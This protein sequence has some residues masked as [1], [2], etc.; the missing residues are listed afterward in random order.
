VNPKLSGTKHNVFGIQTGVAISF[1]V[2]R[3]TRQGYRIFYARRPEFETADEKLEF[4]GSA[5]MERIKFDEI[6]PD[7]KGNWINLADTDFDSLLPILDPETKVASKSSREKAIF[8]LFGNGVNTARDEWVTDF[9]GS[10]LESKVRLFLS[11]YARHTTK[12][13]HHD[14]VIKWSRNLKSKLD[15]GQREL[16]DRAYVRTYAYRPYVAVYAYL[17]RLMIDELGQLEAF[18]AS[19]NVTIN[20]PAGKDFRC[21]ATTLPSD[22]HYI[23]DTKVLGMYRYDDT[24]RRVDN[25]TDWALHQ[26]DKQYQ[27][28][29]AKPKRPID[30][31]AIFHYVYGVLHDPVYREKYTLNLKREF[32]RIPLYANFWR[33]SDWGKELMELHISYESVAPAKMKRTDV[34]DE[35][36]KKAGL[37]PKAMLKAD[38]EAGRI[39]LDSETTLADIPPEA[40]EYRLGNRSA[41]EWILDQYR[42]SK[43][44]DPT[45]R[46]K[47]DAYRFADYKDKVIELLMRVTTVSVRTVAIVRAMKDAAR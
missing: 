43:P 40:W 8:K 10:I 27:P 3:E 7:A 26:F 38:K 33:W 4:I 15:R 11:E 28:S 20:I 24:G 6:Q 25:I 34:A 2:K 17:S 14:T 19:D 35:K 30:K 18:D 16:F 42:E 31:E 5:K 12:A 13:K 36:A 45:I 32:P 41:L 9:S 47:F 29:R 46:E 1:L 21:L 37:A 44:K 22:F 39:V 23:G